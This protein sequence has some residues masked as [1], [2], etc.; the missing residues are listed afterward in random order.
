MD[1]ETHSKLWTACEQVAREQ[2]ARELSH[3][4]SLGIGGDDPERVRSAVDA[5]TP[6]VDELADKIA[7]LEAALEATGNAMNAL[8]ITE[9]RAQLAKARAGLRK[10]EQLD[11][12]A[13]ASSRPFMPAD[14]AGY[15]SQAADIAGDTLAEIGDDG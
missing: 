8:G 4:S 14:P 2:V 13:N 5:L 12:A 10:I 11:E 1:S 15:V 7:S 9:L 6:L 3:A